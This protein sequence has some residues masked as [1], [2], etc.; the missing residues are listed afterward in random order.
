LILG[1]LPWRDDDSLESMN[2][3]MTR[4]HGAK[5]KFADT[6]PISHIPSEFSAILELVDA[7]P[8]HLLTAI[9]LQERTLRNLS[10][11]IVPLDTI[12]LDLTQIHAPISLMNA[13][14]THTRS[15]PNNDEKEEEEIEDECED[16]YFP[17]SYGEC[18]V[19]DW[20]IQGGRDKTLTFPTEEAKLLDGQI[21]DLAQILEE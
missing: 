11:P 5:R 2:S 3:A 10:V 13:L 14:V 9:T 17:N 18:D 4:V 19:G 6:L 20:D 16:D 15:I 8:N 1:D 7:S 21:P 12:S